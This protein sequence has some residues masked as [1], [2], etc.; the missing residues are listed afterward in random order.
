MILLLNIL[1]PLELASIAST[2]FDGIVF[3]T[4]AFQPSPLNTATP[5]AKNT[6]STAIKLRVATLP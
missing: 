6:A 4:A 2:H 3:P 1:Q 5:V